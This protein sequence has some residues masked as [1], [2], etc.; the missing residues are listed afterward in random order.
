MPSENESVAIMIPS[1]GA[2]DTG[3][4]KNVH[5]N[6]KSLPPKPAL[7]SI[8]Q[9]L[10]PDLL[11]ALRFDEEMSLMNPRPPPPFCCKE[12]SGGLA[13]SRPFHN[14]RLSELIKP[15]MN[16]L[17]SAPACK[18]GFASSV[19]RAWPGGREARWTTSTFAGDVCQM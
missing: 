3:R 18:L 14:A 9:L 1:D 4:G 13:L 10:S 6:K 19:F 5:L 2:V 15:T 8:D 12:M 11:Q 17:L 7:I 16:H